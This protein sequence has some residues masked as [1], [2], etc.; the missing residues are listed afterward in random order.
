MTG[1]VSPIAAQITARAKEMIPKFE[2]RVFEGDVPQGNEIPVDELGRVR[3]YL[4][5][6]YGGLQRVAR[7]RRGITTVRDDLKIHTLL[8]LVTGQ[9]V[10]QAN[11]LSDDVR[12]VFEGFEPEGASEMVEETSGNAK[13]PADSTLKP[14]RYTNMLAYSL[15]V[16]P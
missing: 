3:P 9:T 1:K 14:T 16:N 4:T 10:G 12:D 2:G 5:I 8:F 13:Y 6:I 15:L 7:A 11:D